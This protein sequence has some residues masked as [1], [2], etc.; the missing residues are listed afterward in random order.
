MLQRHEAPGL[1]LRSAVLHLSFLG[2]QALPL[3]FSSLRVILAHML[4]T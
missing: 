4:V 1:H 2:L 3:G